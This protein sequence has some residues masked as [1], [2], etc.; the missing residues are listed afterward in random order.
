MR[1]SIL[2]KYL[3]CGETWLHDFGG[4]YDSYISDIYFELITAVD[5]TEC[6]LDMIFGTWCIFSLNYYVAF[7]SNYII[8]VV[9]KYINHL[10]I[11]K[12]TSRS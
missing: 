7:C 2:V 5:T 3:I 9:A 11:K 8:L 12:N 4:I 6:R 1:E 10:G